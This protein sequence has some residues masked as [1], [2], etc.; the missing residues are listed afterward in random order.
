MSYA[1]DHYIIFPNI[2][3]TQA[4]AWFAANLQYDVENGKCNIN[5]WKPG[6]LFGA[7]W[8]L[9][10]G[11][12]IDKA[13]SSLT[14]SAL[15]DLKDWLDNNQGKILNSR[16]EWIDTFEFFW[17]AKERFNEENGFQ[18]LVVGEMF[19]SNFETIDRL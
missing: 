11:L 1:T 18:D 3:T 5:T 10:R 14:P 6:I 2:K 7:T 17:G 19:D 13:T 4:K 15:Q 9:Y 16:Q 12:E 8:T